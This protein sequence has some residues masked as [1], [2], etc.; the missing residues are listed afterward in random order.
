[1]AHSFQKI[2]SLTLGQ[3][4]TGMEALWPQFT[5]HHWSP[6]EVIWKGHLQPL[7]ICN[8]YEVI[9]SY[10]LNDHPKVRVLTPKLEAH[11]NGDPIPHVYPGNRLC[12]YL[13]GIG[14]WH[15]TKMLSHTIIPWASLWLYYY[16]IWHATG[17]W[18]GGG[19]MPCSGLT[20]NKQ[21]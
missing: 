6:S 12:L 7:A 17:T 1:M 20:P 14:E 19:V 21:K 11:Q 8:K 18:K 15:P 10:K 9:I 16:E 4:V 3:Q 2:K 5:R 13:P